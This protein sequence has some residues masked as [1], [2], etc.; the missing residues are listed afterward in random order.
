MIDMEAIVRRIYD[1]PKIDQDLLALIKKKRSAKGSGN[2][3]MYSDLFVY[4][5]LNLYKVGLTFSDIEK[6]HG[7][8]RN[9]VRLW[10]SE[11]LGVILK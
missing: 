5:A 9:T 3:S 11:Y 1:L 2:K 4:I 10:T 7:V 8:S 6:R